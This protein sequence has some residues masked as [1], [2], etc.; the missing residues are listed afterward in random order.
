VIAECAEPGNPV[1][2][3]FNLDPRCCLGDVACPIDAG[4]C[5]DDDECD[6]ALVWGENNCNS[7]IY[8]EDTNCCQ[9]T[10]YVN[11]TSV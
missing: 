1:S 10:W 4:F 7:A 8:G 3:D 2:P 6:G 5:N 11:T 9:G